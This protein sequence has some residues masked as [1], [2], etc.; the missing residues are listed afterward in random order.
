MTK[1][2]FISKSES[3]VSMRKELQHIF[4]RNIG[5]FVSVAYNYATNN[6]DAFQ[7]NH[8]SQFPITIG[9]VFTA[10]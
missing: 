4:N 5:G 9:L 2:I 6:N 10:P 3:C 8:L 1:V 7:I